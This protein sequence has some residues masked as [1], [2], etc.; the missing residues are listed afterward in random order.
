MNREILRLAI[1][2]IIANISV[3]MLGIV[4]TAL[5]GHMEAV[6]YIGALAVGTRVLISFISVWDFFRWEPRG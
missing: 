6:Y 4:D 2:N 5:V 1:P 3:P